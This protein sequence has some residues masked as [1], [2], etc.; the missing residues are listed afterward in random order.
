MLFRSI[1]AGLA[2]GPLFKEGGAL[3]FMGRMSAGNIQTAAG[4]L[5]G[6]IGAAGGLV[7][8]FSPL[9]DAITRER[10]AG[11]PASAIRVG[12][13][14]ALKS[15]GNPGGLGVYNTIHEPGGLGQGIS[16]SRKMGI[17]PKTHG[18][19]NFNL[20]DQFGNPIS[21]GRYQGPMSGAGFAAAIGQQ[22]FFSNYRPPQKPD[23]SA[24]MQMK[25]AEK[26]A[27]SVDKFN[28]GV[29]HFMTF[30]SMIGFM[31]APAINER[32]GLDANDQ[33]IQMGLTGAFMGQMIGQG[34]G[35]AAGFVG[36]RAGQAGAALSKAAG[37]RAGMLGRGLGIAGRG[38]S[39]AGRFVPHP[40]VR[41]GLMLGGTALG[42][43]MGT[44]MGTEDP[45]DKALRKRTE[46]ANKE[47]AEAQ[48]ALN[49]GEAFVNGLR[50]LAG[51]FNQLQGPQRTQAFDS[52]QRSY[53]TFI[54]TLSDSD[55]KKVSEAFNNLTKSLVDQSGVSKSAEN[56]EKVI[57]ALG[58]SLDKVKKSAEGA[59]SAIELETLFREIN[60]GA[61]TGGKI[62][63]AHV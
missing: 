18:I 30:G 4:K 37:S 25:S 55:A 23:P 41:G 60:K 24:Q 49:A 45:T 21:S 44:E 53:D 14:P 40:I 17:N 59:K 11:V 16:R 6:T 28:T 8:N 36:Q 58:E 1:E 63:R 42:A 19:P 35:T 52:L 33:R 38:M 29:G 31:A 7:P 3:P 51:N 48:E 39:A 34:A 12:S 62:G 54:T 57:G 32:L 10:A 22:S 5:R 15:S 50:D 26:L 47:M 61:P 27:A 43:Y 13:S 9:T 20:V 56:L 46:A 2:K